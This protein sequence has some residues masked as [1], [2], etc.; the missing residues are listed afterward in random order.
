M[1]GYVIVT[2]KQSIFLLLL[3]LS[4]DRLLVSNLCGESG[5]NIDDKQ[6]SNFKLGIANNVDA[7]NTEWPQ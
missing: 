6:I 7:P 5:E 3:I 4:Y 2:E 1:I